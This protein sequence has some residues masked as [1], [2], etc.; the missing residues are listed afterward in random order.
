MDIPKGPGELRK[1]AR[2]ESFDSWILVG[3]VDGNQLVR[4][5]TDINGL[6]DANFLLDIGKSVLMHSMDAPKN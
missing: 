1:L 4:W 3:F 2:E 5:S 6:G